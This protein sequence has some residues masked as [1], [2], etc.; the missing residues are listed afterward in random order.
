MEKTLKKHIVILA[1]GGTIAGTGKAGATVDYHPGEL[2]IG[3]IIASVDGIEDLA[4]IT[5]EQ[6]V[7]VDSV[8]I[9][10]EIWIRLANRI[11]ELA[12]MTNAD[13]FV[14]THGTDTLEETA[15][16]LNLAVH[17]DKPVI[18][19][20][21][22]RPSTAISADGPLN[23]YESVALASSDSA[24]GK[25]VMVLLSDRFYSAREVTKTNTF[26]T[27]TFSGKD[28]GCLGYMR[29]QLPYFFTSTLKCHTSQTEFDV[30]RIKQLPKVEVA[31][32]YAGADPETLGYLMEKSDGMVIAGAGDGNFSDTWKKEL[33]KM[34]SN[35][36]PV[37]IASR[38][39]SGVV[40]LPSNHPK[41]CISSDTLNPQ[42]ARI[43]LQLALTRTH[44]ISGIR[45]I[46][47][48]Y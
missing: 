38:T 34:E 4:S 32:F 5:S 40:T 11:N 45:E 23:L 18:V 21:A 27:D 29:D 6:I 47:E 25:G 35:N 19:T 44:E 48:K 10:S 39:S 26:E 14:V 22:M 36:K 2:D 13:G 16:F 15:Y 3:T 31:Y 37:V 30:S 17:T 41:N 46:F 28:G 8:C 24:F 20:G 43:L 33:I 12:A 42:K 1:T 7:N 9:T